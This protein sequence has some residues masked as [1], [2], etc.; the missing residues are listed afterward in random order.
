MEFKFVK[1]G[2]KYENEKYY[3]RAYGDKK[4]EIIG[5]YDWIKENCIHTKEYCLVEKKTEYY[6]LCFDIDF[7][8]DLDECYKDS[9][10]KIT[11]YIIEKINESIKK[12]I[13]SCEILYVYAETTKGLG[14]HIYYTSIIVDRTLHMKI[15]NT[16][17]GLIE[18]DK[19]YNKIIIEKIIDKTVCEQNGIR[20][21][22][23]I[24]NGGYYY[25]VKE[26]STKEISGDIDKDFD[27]CLLN[28]ET[29]GYNI[30]PKIE[31]ELEYDSDYEEIENKKTSI[32][33][34]E[35]KTSIVK[36][37]KTNLIEIR[38]LL[39]I[40]QKKNQKYEDWIRV[41]MSLFG[42]NETDDMKEIWKE[43]SEI[44]YD[45][46]PKQYSSQEEEINSK[47]ESFKIGDYPLTIGTIKKMTKD[48]DNEKYVEWYN[49]HNKKEIINLVKDFDQQTVS[50]YFKNKKPDSY[51]Y[52]KGEWYTLMN[53]NLWH[54]VYKNENSKLIND[55][56]ETI[57]IDL[58]ELKNC[59]KPEDEMLKS[60]PTVS[61]KLGTSKFIMGVIDFLREKYRNDSV[62]FDMKS[63]LFGFTNVVYDLEQNEFRK[64][65][66]DDM[67][68]ITTGYDWK[69]PKEE[70]LK[71]VN[72]MLKE[73]HNKEDIRYFYLD[74]YCSGLW[75]ITLQNYIIFNGSGS[76]G[77]SIMD[78][79]VLKSFGNY[80]HVIN[81]IILC[82]QRRQGA[83]TEIA[84]LSKKRLVIAREPPGK[85]N[86]KL[87]NSLLKELTGGSEI[88]ARKIYS[89]DEKTI[90]FITLILEC[91]KRPL[92]EEEP[93]EADMRR[94][95]DLLFESRF[96][97]DIDDTNGINIF[98]KNKY[99]EENEFK[100]KH[101]YALMKIL[102]DHNKN[103][104]RKKLVVPEAVK[105]R[106][107]SYM[108]SSVEIFEWFNETYE[109][110]VNPTVHDYV[111]ISDINDELKISE[112]Y[113][114]LEKKEKRKLTREK[115]IKTFKESPVFKNFYK[116]EIDSHVNGERFK[117]PVRINGYK[118]KL[119]E[120]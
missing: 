23:C 17:I 98:M 100:D 24:K 69:E 59:L 7:K 52:K 31:I 21:F 102:F 75:G 119:V 74:V 39:E 26:K 111:K 46:K 53:N 12:I 43:W 99:Y 18:K 112:Y 56:T 20:L 29:K 11:K 96:V 4:G 73:I 50:I 105:M 72:K 89:D 81:S 51:I 38:E 104:Y 101:K 10:E 110:I 85:Q 16:M 90:L 88:S 87:S 82:E 54:H 114:S 109:K 28:R 48:L 41:G 3:V 32:K 47:W 115:I 34:V 45:W 62:E 55:I 33:K 15:Y 113:N 95:L 8:E 71:T 65:R 49:S 80:G 42:E 120:D 83:N 22:G 107:R 61:K 36:Y 30:T 44:N 67:V 57:K 78:D 76:N 103:H 108:E 2:E 64:Y 118:R 60:I 116:D 70:E 35:Q 94:L 63:N 58:I 13:M 66:K 19:K 6:M 25:P 86:V 27:Y 9:H 91:N 40:I 14:K 117:A 68:S 77:K 1:S 97:D 84:N 37:K 106:T 92:M 5:T 93:T 79:L